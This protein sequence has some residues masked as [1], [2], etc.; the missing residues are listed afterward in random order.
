MHIKHTAERC[1]LECYVFKSRF[2]VT[3]QETFSKC[4]T[5]HMPTVVRINT[6]LII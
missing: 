1:K 4:G 3:L 2:I 5:L 6:N